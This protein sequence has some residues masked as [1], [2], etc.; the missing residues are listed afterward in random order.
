MS[1][2]SEAMSRSPEAPPRKAPPR[3]TPPRSTPPRS[4]NELVRYVARITEFDRTDW[5]VYLGWAIFEP[6][7]FPH[8]PATRPT[9]SVS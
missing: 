2:S 4:T 8:I 9:R 3:S 6:A 7:R 5:L 1:R